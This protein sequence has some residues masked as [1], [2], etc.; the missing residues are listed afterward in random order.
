MYVHVK[1]DECDTYYPLEILSQFIPCKKAQF[2]DKTG[3]MYDV[4]LQPCTYVDQQSKK[5]L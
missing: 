1:G 5:E 3:R 4:W 2:K